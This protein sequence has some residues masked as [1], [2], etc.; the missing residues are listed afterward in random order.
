VETRT[1]GSASGLGNEPM[2][3]SGTAPQADSTDVDRS[4]V[5]AATPESALPRATKKGGVHKTRDGSNSAKS[6]CLT[7]A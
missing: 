7:T 4:T 1:A 3:T 5:A 2:A 6:E